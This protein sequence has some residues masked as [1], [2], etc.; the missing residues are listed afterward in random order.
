LFEFRA[1]GTLSRARLAS[2]SQG[3]GAA[4]GVG[5]VLDVASLRA[6]AVVASGISQKNIKPLLPENTRIWGDYHEMRWRG[7][8][9][10]NP[11]VQ[12]K[13]GHSNRLVASILILQDLWNLYLEDEGKPRSDCPIVGLWQD[14][15]PGGVVLRHLQLKPEDLEAVEEGQAAAVLPIGGVGA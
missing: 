5:E 12:R 8:Y 3:K 2:D 1:F 4:P 11:S 15:A 7:I 13:W 14:P 10:A 9:A 6:S